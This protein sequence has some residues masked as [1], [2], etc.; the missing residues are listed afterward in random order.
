MNGVRPE[1]RTL[2]EQLA[3]G[4]PSESQPSDN[5]E[6]CRSH[7]SHR[8]FTVI[9]GASVGDACLIEPAVRCNACGYCQSLGH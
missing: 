8:F 4:L 3:R 2:L 1:V 6:V 5:H 9:Q 7:V